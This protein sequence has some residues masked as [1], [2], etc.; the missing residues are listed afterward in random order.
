LPYQLLMILTLSEP[1]TS[2]NSD[3]N[4]QGLLYADFPVEYKTKQI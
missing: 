4:M 2:A 1:I 3:D